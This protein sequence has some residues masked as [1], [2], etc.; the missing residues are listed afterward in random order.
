MRMARAIIDKAILAEL[1]QKGYTA[2]QISEMIGFKVDSVYKMAHRIGLPKHKSGPK[3]I[4]ETDKE[5]K[6]WFIR[7][8]PLMS[9]S[10]ISVFL[11]ISEDYIGKI[12]RRLRLKKS[13]EY[14]QGIREYQRKRIRQFHDAKKGDRDYYSYNARLRKNGKFTKRESNEDLY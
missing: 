3:S 12:A 14:W 11:G 5:K 2:P 4:L 10:T 7:N 6:K 9:N 13:E 8:Y 1:W